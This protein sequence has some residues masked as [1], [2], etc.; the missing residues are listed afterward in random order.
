MRNLSPFMSASFGTN[1]T[2]ESLYR[3]NSN[4]RQTL[5]Q[6]IS[7][8][9]SEVTALEKK[10]KKSPRK[11]DAARMAAGKKDDVPDEFRCPITREL[12]EEPVMLLDGHS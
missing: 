9:K 4:V 3:A 10:L 5:E 11:I 2:I 6:M 7:F 1:W 12:M 8:E